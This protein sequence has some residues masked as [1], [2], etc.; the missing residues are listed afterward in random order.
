MGSTCADVRSVTRATYAM[1]TWTTALVTSASTVPSAL[2]GSAATSACAAP[3]TRGNSAR[4]KGGTVPVESARTTARAAR[5]ETIS[6]VSVCGASLESIVNQPLLITVLVGRATSRQNAE[7][8]E[9]PSSASVHREPQDI[10]ATSPS[11]RRNLVLM[12][13]CVS[14]VVRQISLAFALSAIQVTHVVRRSM[15]RRWPGTALPKGAKATVFAIPRV[16]C[17]SVRMTTPERHVRSGNARRPTAQVTLC[18]TQR[19][20]VANASPGT[21]EKTA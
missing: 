13:D 2:T 19:A 17:V 4:R 14:W 16:V 18:A 1:S 7:T 21:R 20:V 12:V 10:F 15:L 5:S 6:A 3:S 8:K 11:V 9:I